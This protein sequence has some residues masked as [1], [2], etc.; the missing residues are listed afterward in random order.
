MHL[1]RDTLDAVSQQWRT[2]PIM[3][4]QHPHFYGKDWASTSKLENARIVGLDSV[5]TLQKACSDLE[6]K[7]DIDKRWDPASDE[8]NYWDDH[9][10]QHNYYRAIDTLEGLV[11]SRLFE[12]T[13]M[14]QS[15]TGK[16]LPM[17]H[18][19]LTDDLV[20]GYKLRSKISNALHARSAAI[21]TAI[22]SYNEA[23]LRLPVPGP[24]LDVKTVLDYVFL[25]EFDL[26][27][28]SRHHVHDKAWTR[29]AER[30]AMNTWFKIQHSQEEIDRVIIE[31]RCLN[32]WMHD[33]QQALDTCVQ[34]LEPHDQVLAYQ[35]AKLC[36]YKQEVNCAH[37][38][39]IH[40]MEG[41]H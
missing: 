21:C 29:P 12:L 36:K 5:L 28:D 8:W 27:W 24:I 38:E 30:L 6:C 41:S 25:A 11:V 16:C 7:L 37:A 17:S 14:N 22:K 18:H 10:A 13:K 35:V 15:E 26:L 9:L 40:R 33:E 4:L 23:A 34:S 20:V 31:A 39:L 3:E 19:V 1:N 2:I 32:T